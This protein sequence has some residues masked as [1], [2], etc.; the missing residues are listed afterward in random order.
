MGHI[1]EKH[2]GNDQRRNYSTFRG[3]DQGN[4]YGNCYEGFVSQVL[5]KT[6]D[7]TEV[8]SMGVPF[9]WTINTSLHL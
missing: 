5:E 8:F 4:R 1:V 9:D 2:R 6:T 7:M 3:N